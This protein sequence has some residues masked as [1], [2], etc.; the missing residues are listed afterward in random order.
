MLPERIWTLARYRA[1][2]D[3]MRLRDVVVRALEAYLARQSRSRR[4]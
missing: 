3:R 4:R 2:T 1:V